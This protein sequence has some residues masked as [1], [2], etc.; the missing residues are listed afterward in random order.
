MAGSVFSSALYAGLFPTGAVGALFTDAAEIRAMM[1]VEGAL[2]RVQGRAGLIPEPAAEAIHRASRE[3]QIDAGALAEATGANGVPVPALVAAFREAMQ[4]PGHAQYLH[5]GA[6]SQD[7]VDTALMLRAKR[8]LGHQI[9]ML[10]AC[11]GRL[12]DLA[13]RHAAQPMA[14][15]TYGQHATPTSFG[16]VAAEWGR[17]LLGLR[18]E[19]AALAA[20]LPVSLSGAAGTAEALGPDAPNLRAALARELGLHDPG[21]G[22]HT[23]RTPLLRLADWHGRAAAA[24]AKIGEDL[25]LAV[26]SGIAEVRLAGSGGSSTMPQ[27]QNPVGPA[28]IVALAAGVQAQSSALGWVGAHR[29][30]RDG[31][32]WFAEWI[33]VPPMVLGLA[34]ALARAAEALHGLAPDTAAMA[35]T[36]A[37]G[38]GL[39]A[40]EALSFALA[41]RM[42]RAEAQAEVKGLARTV[43]AE[44]GHL[45][46]A[47]LAK[48]PDLDPGLFDPAAQLGQA[49]AEARAFAA[50]VRAARPD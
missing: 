4:A 17:P 25:I 42:P 2:A 3:L 12:A 13:D 16:A 45:R 49:P 14:A 22:W 38:Q 24:L 1:L 41:R 11:L 7:I 23:D 21:A 10:D 15:R 48:W 6:T 29:Q 30:Q 8:A 9:D 40:A 47:A 26:Q 18:T 31:A 43:A 35:R 33:A 20:E 44:G 32:R 28:A 37:S 46:D 50:R 5:W 36:L 39:M 19:G 27:K 34:A